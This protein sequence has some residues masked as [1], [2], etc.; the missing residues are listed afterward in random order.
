VKIVGKSEASA[1]SYF[2]PGGGD[3]VATSVPI[4]A[5]GKR[6]AASATY[7]NSQSNRSL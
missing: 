4:T 5:S 1:P 6:L 7:D 3:V 2:V